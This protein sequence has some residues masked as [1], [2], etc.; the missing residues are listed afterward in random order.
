MEPESR[1][2]CDVVPVV[3]VAGELLELDVVC[4][5]DI[6]IDSLC[7]AGGGADQGRGQR[8]GH[9]GVFAMESSE[10]NLA[11]RFLIVI[12]GFYRFAERKTLH[13]GFL[14]AMEIFQTIATERGQC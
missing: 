3:P 11:G 8:G 14:A 2:V 10:G 5:A 7:L 12:H 1:A 9:Q 4:G 13:V 6:N